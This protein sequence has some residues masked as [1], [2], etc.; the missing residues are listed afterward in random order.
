MDALYISF[1]AKSVAEISTDGV[2]PAVASAVHD[3][4]GVWLHKSRYTLE[5]VG[6][7]LQS[8]QSD[9][10]RHQNGSRTTR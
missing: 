2:A 10:A 7:A 9:R 1:G 6:Q 5:R 3:V 4:I 8:A